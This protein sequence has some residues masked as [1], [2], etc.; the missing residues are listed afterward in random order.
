MV[1]FGLFDE[2][3]TKERSRKPKNIHE[4]AEKVKEL[5]E[6]DEEKMLKEIE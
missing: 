2:K 4:Q 6:T 5:I 1:V 3:N